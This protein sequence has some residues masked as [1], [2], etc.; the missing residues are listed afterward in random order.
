MKTNSRRGSSTSLFV[1]NKVAPANNNSN[2]NNNDNNSNNNSNNNDNNDSNNNAPHLADATSHKRVQQTLT[3]STDTSIDDTEDVIRSDSQQLLA[4]GPE[5]SASPIMEPNVVGKTAARKYSLRLVWYCAFMYG[6][7]AFLY[8]FL[9]FFFP[10]LC[11][12]DPSIG[13]L[14]M[15]SGDIGIVLSVQSAVAIVYNIVF[16]HHVSAWFGMMRLLR[17][18]IIAMIPMCI[19]Y[20]TTALANGQTTLVWVL[21]FI[22]SN[23]RCVLSLVRWWFFFLFVY[24]FCYQ[25]SLLIVFFRS[26]FVFF[27]VIVCFD[28]NCFV[29]LLFWHL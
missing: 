23:I 4:V 15:T 14:G 16:F 10:L 3:L 12:D 29:Q 9:D 25:M 8:A 6:L 11:R 26:F 2:S 18:S 5:L 7:V 19:A 1:S 17:W 21:V 13:G 27:V 20:P 24:H 28:T 22:N